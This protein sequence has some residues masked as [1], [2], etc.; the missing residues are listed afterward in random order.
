MSVWNNL[1]VITID[2]KFRNWV[3]C[4]KTAQKRLIPDP[5]PFKE[6]VPPNFQGFQ[7][8]ALGQQMRET[9]A[10][11]DWASFDKPPYS[12]E[13]LIV[14][15]YRCKPT[16][17]VLNPKLA[18]QKRCLNLIQRLYLLQINN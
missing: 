10:V 1:A 14:F 17:L 18:P 3:A 9:P 11:I 4:W 6:Q 15:I 7:R 16:P 12:K 13:D 8:S 2:N 5:V